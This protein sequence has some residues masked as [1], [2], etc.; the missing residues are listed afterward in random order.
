MQ[1]KTG[2]AA[3]LVRLVHGW[4]LGSWISWSFPLPWLK[5][6]MAPKLFVETTWFLLN[7]CFP[8]Q[9]L[10]GWYVTGTGCLHGFVQSLSQ[11]GLFWDA[12]DGSSPDS[13]VHGISQVRILE[14]ITIYFSRESSQPRD[15]THW[16]PTALASGFFTT[17]PS[18]ELS[19]PDPSY[20][21]GCWNS[22]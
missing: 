14:W 18:E 11:V 8:L 12:M 5:W 1:E 13:S 2:L 19:W 10:E 9:S 7:I 20:N 16:L 22:R 17:E 21:S 6:L 15:Q 3:I 4:H